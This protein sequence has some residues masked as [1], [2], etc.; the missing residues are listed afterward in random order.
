ML[1][2]MVVRRGVWS[3]QNIDRMYKIDMIKN[4]STRGLYETGPV[5]SR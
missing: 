1:S 2:F 4:A 5:Y 3:P